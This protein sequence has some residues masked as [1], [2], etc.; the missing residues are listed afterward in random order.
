[1][2]S[3]ASAHKS[4]ADWQTCCAAIIPCL[5]EE[6]AIGPLVSAVRHHLRTVLVVDDGSVDQTSV[7]ASR[8]GAQVVRHSRTLGKG[9]SLR[10]GWAWALDR[11]FGW[12]MNLDGDGQHCAED[13]PAFL[14]YAESHS[15]SLVVGNR[16]HD[17]HSMPPL[18]WLANR[19]LSRKLSR[20]AGRPFP[21]SQCGFRLMNLSEWKALGGST[22]NFFEIESEV[23]LTFA[24]SN[25]GIGFVPIRVLYKGERSKIHPIHDTWRWFAWWRKLDKRGPHR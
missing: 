22:S 16:M 13:I 4:R 1:M 11:G 25:R 15:V 21:D 9:S 20:R 8:A 12:A 10:T 3:S 2:Q 24:S 14:R 18:R 19:W 6:A 5:N 17:P 7:L 23:L